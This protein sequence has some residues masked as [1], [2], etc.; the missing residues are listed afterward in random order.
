MIKRFSALFIVLVL[1]F[2]YAPIVI[3]MAY[4][5]TDA[6]TIGAIRGFSLHNYVT[7]FTTPDL[8]NMIFGTILLALV[9]ALLATILGTLGAAN[10]VRAYETYRR[11]GLLE[12]LFGLGTV[13]RE[14][15]RHVRRSIVHTGR[16]MPP[17][18]RSRSAT[19]PTAPRPRS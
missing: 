7:L 13:R 2:M 14:P 5:F 18:R 4:S 1:I 12:S 6:T 19:R 10:R 3:L 9:S 17:P 15:P 8:R 16:P 11:P